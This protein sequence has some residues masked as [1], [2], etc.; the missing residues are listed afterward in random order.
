MGVKVSKPF[1]QTQ[2]F[3]LEFEKYIIVNSG[4]RMI[5]KLY[6]LYSDV[7]SLLTPIVAQHGYHFVQIGSP[8]DVQVNGCLDLRGKTNL[9]QS[10]F[11]I[12]NCEL[13]ISNDTSCMHIASGF[14]K[15]LVALFGTT[16]PENHGAYFG[17]KNNQ[18]NL[19]S[20]R[21][22]NKPSFASDESPRTI[23]LVKVEDVCTAVLKLLNI[24]NNLTQKS[25][26]VGDLYCQPHHEINF[27]PD[28]SLPDDVAG[29]IIM[30]CDLFHDLNLIIQNLQRRKFILRLNQE[31]DLN[32]LQQLKPN[33]EA[34][35]FEIDETTDVN[36]LK[37][38][39][40]L[41]IGL[42]LFTKLSIEEH[43]AIKLK[44]LDLPIVNR[45]EKTSLDQVKENIKKYQNSTE[46]P[47]LTKE[48][49]YYSKKHY[50]SQGKIFNSVQDFRIQKSVYNIEEK[51]IANLQDQNFL[52]EINHFL[53]FS[54]NV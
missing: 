30:R 46:P 54:S 23:S 50:L 51:S 16:Q 20:H 21:N 35:L 9:H 3:P 53:L 47:D 14:D 28:Y 6:P 24:E 5:G 42:N 19:V 38:I 27:I 29:Q 11:L 32:I 33:I 34:I 12:Q 37:N 25:L 40:K 41:G 4:G 15:N 1:I 43:N 52:N 2:Y 36:Y 7:I 18:I 22:G 31:I 45:L 17:D 39:Q 26:L 10:A 49:F 13:L 44:Y 8:E 48:Y